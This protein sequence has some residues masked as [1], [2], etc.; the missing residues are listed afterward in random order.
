LQP[1]H[2]REPCQEM[3]TLLPDITSD[4]AFSFAADVGASWQCREWG[5]PHEHI[6][7]TAT[8]SVGHGR[9]AVASKP[10]LRNVVGQRRR[11][12]SAQLESNLQ[13]PRLVDVSGS[14]KCCTEAKLDAD[15]APAESESC[16]HG[17]HHG[18]VLL[19]KVHSEPKNNRAVASKPCLASIFGLATDEQ[20]SRSAV[21]SSNPTLSDIFLLSNFEEA[22]RLVCQL[23]PQDA[24]CENSGIVACSCAHDQT[25]N[26]APGLPEDEHFAQVQR[27]NLSG[28]A[29]KLTDIFGVPACQTEARVTGATTGAAEVTL[30]SS[31]QRLWH[32]FGRLQEEPELQS[33]ESDVGAVHASALRLT[34]AV[35]P[36]SEDG[37]FMDKQLPLDWSVAPRHGSLQSTAESSQAPWQDGLSNC[38]TTYDEEAVRATT[39]TSPSS[40]NV[41]NGCFVTRE[42]PFAGRC[43]QLDKNSE[44]L[45]P[46]SG[47]SSLVQH[48]G[49][50]R[51]VESRNRSSLVQRCGVKAL[52]PSLSISSLAQRRSFFGIQPM[53]VRPRNGANAVVRL[54]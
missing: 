49:V 12:P 23:K 42:L 11:L 41:V 31:G 33:S 13:V 14:F 3:P 20:C 47:S 4:G 25:A 29:P 44:V 21:F 7:C 9:L 24:C 1:R 35:G 54:W 46:F 37:D 50:K 15:T 18:G 22:Q 53:C 10:S 48:H 16:K 36:T 30:P 27:D 40:G 19:S 45:L 52:G 43:P 6:S 28:T 5:T 2:R 34:D 8:A 26:F 51:L 38:S 32:I 17:D 39:A